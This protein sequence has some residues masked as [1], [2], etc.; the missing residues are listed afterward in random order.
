MTADIDGLVRW[1]HLDRRGG[2]MTEHEALNE[3][4]KQTEKQQ[5]PREILVDIHGQV[6]IVMPA[7][8]DDFRSGADVPCIR[9]EFS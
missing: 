2:D 5:I 4:A 6:W 1:D 7:N 3:W 9:N 8:G